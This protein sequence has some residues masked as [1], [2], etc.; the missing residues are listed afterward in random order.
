MTEDLVPSTS[1]TT[2]DGFEAMVA[3]L[4]QDER[5]DG[6]VAGWLL[7]FASP[8]TRAAYGRDLQAWLGFCASVGARPL[9]ARRAH[10]DAWARTLEANGLSPATVARRLS[11]VSSWYSWLIAED[12][13][14]SSP[15]AHVRRP[16]VSDES[17]TLGPTVDEARALLAAAEYLGSK[18]EALISLLLLNGLRVG[19][20]VS[21]NVSDLG[22]ERGHRVLR[23]ARNGGRVALVPLAPRTGAAI[24]AYLDGRTEGPLLIGELHGRGT[25]GRLSV[26]GAAYMV[27]RTARAAGVD[28][29]L[30]P[31]SLRHAFV[32]IALEAGVPLHDVQDAAG[33]ADPRTTERYNRARHGLDA[34]PTYAL[35]AALSPVDLR[36]G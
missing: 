28:K 1:P 30:S 6:L 31:H 9:G 22:G 2:P 15:L 18:Y 29:R 19:E 13:L 25:T 36:A 11:G 24:D 3:G 8:H 21:A 20:V 23:L 10:V 35:A 17:A 14:E 27:R 7:G 5:L 4:R 34:A 12:V 26:A 16:R 33:H 32:T